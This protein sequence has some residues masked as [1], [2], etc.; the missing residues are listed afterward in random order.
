V[1]A[2]LLSNNS[3]SLTFLILLP[4]NTEKLF[5]RKKKPPLETVTSCEVF[6]DVFGGF[7]F[8]KF[9]VQTILRVSFIKF[10]LDRWK[11]GGYPKT[12][13]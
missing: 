9:V 5:F 2:I 4:K 11:T 10:S 3:N 6:I 1:V 7:F 12:L 13:K 8:T